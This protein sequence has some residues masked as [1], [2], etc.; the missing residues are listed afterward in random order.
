MKHTDFYYLFK[1]VK[2]HV[3]DELKAAVKA[4]GGSYSWEDEDDC[5]IVA[6]NPDTSEPEPLDV[7]IHGISFDTYG[8]LVF[9]ATGK[10]S[11]YEIDYLCADDI[12]AEHIGYIIDYMN[13]TPDVSDVSIPFVH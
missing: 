3:I 12:F 9:E 11:G 2:Q 4:H 6:A 5:P 8:D 7:C 1:H 10:E 13:G